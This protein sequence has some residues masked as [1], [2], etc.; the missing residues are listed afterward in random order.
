MQEQK[1]VKSLG[2]CKTPPGCLQ[3]SVQESEC[4][5]N[6]ARER[7]L[8]L[9]SECWLLNTALAEQTK[10]VLEAPLKCFKV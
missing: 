6:V 1:G 5:S 7:V 3:E 2:S 9:N 4:G 8:I 10:V